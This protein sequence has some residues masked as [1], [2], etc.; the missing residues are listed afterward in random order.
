MSVERPLSLRQVSFSGSC[1][2]FSKSGDR[3]FRRTPTSWASSLSSPSSPFKMHAQ[4]LL[5]QK[6]R[7]D[8]LDALNALYSG[9][10]RKFSKVQMSPI[11]FSWPMRERG[12]CKFQDAFEVKHHLLIA[13]QRNTN[14]DSC[15]LARALLLQP[16]RC[17]RDDGGASLLCTQ[18]RLTKRVASMRDWIPNSKSSFLNTL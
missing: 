16:Y 7:L 1:R 15:P 6:A 12:T 2:K 10:G 11:F 17:P 18:A 4:D 8:Q 9:S 3:F 14:G 13:S 5:L